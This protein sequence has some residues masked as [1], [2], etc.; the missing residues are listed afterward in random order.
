MNNNQPKEAPVEIFKPEMKQFH[1][2]CQIWYS[3][4]PTEIVNHYMAMAGFQSQDKQ[5]AK[6]VALATEKFMFEVITDAQ[7]YGLTHLHSHSAIKP[8]TTMTLE[9]VASALKDRGI[10]VKRPDFVVEQTIN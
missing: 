7:A 1:E 2:N 6:A 3:V 10:N 4:I 5:I 8:V 9:D